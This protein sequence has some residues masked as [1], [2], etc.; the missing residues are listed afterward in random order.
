MQKE[1]QGRQAF[2][3]ESILSQEHIPRTEELTRI[4]GHSCNCKFRGKFLSQPP[5]PPLS[6][7]CSAMCRVHPPF[8]NNDNNYRDLNLWYK[9]YFTG[10]IPWTRTETFPGPDQIQRFRYAEIDFPPLTKDGFSSSVVND[11]LSSSSHS[12]QKFDLMWVEEEPR[13]LLRFGWWCRML[14][15]NR[16]HLRSPVWIGASH[17]HRQSHYIIMSL[18]LLLFM[19]LLRWYN[20]IRAK[21]RGWIRN[22]HSF[23]SRIF[24]EAHRV[25]DG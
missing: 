11:F 2:E 8:T 23:I 4:I 6:H 5:P 12:L 24:F 7:C 20:F 10:P 15:G 16:D 18:A 3:E 13:F 1:T 22:C 17:C 14:I 25:W 9:R 21:R 19:A